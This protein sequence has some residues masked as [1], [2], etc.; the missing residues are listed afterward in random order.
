LPEPGDSS[1][2]ISFHAGR[3][4]TQKKTDMAGREAGFV[5]LVSN[6]HLNFLQDVMT[7]STLVWAAMPELGATEMSDADAIV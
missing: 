5:L 1:P 3:S 7:A 2:S 6:P 4:L